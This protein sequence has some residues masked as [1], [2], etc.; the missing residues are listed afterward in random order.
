LALELDESDQKV[1]DAV[2]QHGFFSQGVFEGSEGPA[3]RYSVGFWE[4]LRSPEVIIF[5]L[6][7]TLMHN[8]LWE[9][10]RQIKSGAELADETR[11][12][13]LIEGFDCI[14]RRVHPSQVGEYLTYALWYRRLRSQQAN[15]LQAYQLFWPG[16]QQGLY[17]WERDCVQ[18]VRDNQPLLYLPRETGIA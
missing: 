6:D 3:F 1:V 14:A 12:S 15:D 2:E 5:G 9:M 10:F 7:L 11:W 16:K 8:M 18:F 13:E 17:P 4:T